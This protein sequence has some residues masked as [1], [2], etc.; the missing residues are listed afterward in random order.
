MLFS[1]FTCAKMSMQQT[2]CDLMEIADLFLLKAGKFWKTI[3]PRPLWLDAVLST[4]LIQ[5]IESSF[6]QFFLAFLS[7]FS[8]A[9]PSAQVHDV[10][11]CLC[12]ASSENLEN[13]PVCASDNKTY[14]NIRLFKCMKSCNLVKGKVWTFILNWNWCTHKI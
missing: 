6:L 10:E 14:S 3:K 2:L 8:Y 9:Y 1:K 13:K 12:L 11:K 4:L 7:N 5:T